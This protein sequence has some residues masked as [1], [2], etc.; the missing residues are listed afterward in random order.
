MSKTFNL[1]LVTPEG[2]LFEGQAASLTLPTETGEITVL[3]NHVPMVSAIASGA[4]S[5]TLE[6]G[7]EED[8][9]IS[10]GFLQIK[11]LN[12]VVI[13][14]QMAERAA[15]LDLKTIE[16]AKMR[17]ET[18]VKEHIRTSDEEY[19][20]TVAILNRE[21]A[22]YKAAVKHRSRAGRG[23]TPNPLGE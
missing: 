17:A 23:H 15:E 20:E 11:G 22:R 8:I 13:L 4:A 19:A 3:P 16:E 2:A 21:L 7:F 6:D 9:A 1:K 18:T 12:E 5:I 10:G 14:A